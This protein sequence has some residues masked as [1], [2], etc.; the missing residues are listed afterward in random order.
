MKVNQIVSEHKK[1][2]RAKKYTTK[3]KG[4]V[5]VYG[6]DS[7]DAKLKPVKP[8]GT[9]NEIES[10]ATAVK[11]NP[12]GSTV[13]KDATGAEKTAAA[14]EIKTGPDGKPT[15]AVAGITPGEQINITDKVAEAP[16][17]RG[18]VGGDGTDRLI[19]AI[20]SDEH[21]LNDEM[22]GKP[23]YVTMQGGKPMVMDNGNT[24]GSPLGVTSSGEEITPQLIARSTD[25]SLKS[26]QLNGKTYPT[27][28][29]GTR[30]YR[31][32]KQAYQEII[33]GAQ[34]RI[35]GTNSKQPSRLFNPA[36][37][38][39]HGGPKTPGLKEADDVLLGKMLTIA[40]LR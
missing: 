10:V 23:Y 34:S 25:W 29:S 11:Q 18:P 20:S 30:G 38:D 28:Y 19:A 24:G 13:Y 32:G 16:T 26:I 5:P 31:V 14:G 12:D 3:A 8:V 21:L 33:A 1:G 15:L 2:V 27:L 22:G 35:M 36:D 7:K 6:P 40:G 4:T 9:L 17:D 39:W 37:V